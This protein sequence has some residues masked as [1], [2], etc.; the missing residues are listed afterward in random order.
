MINYLVSLLIGISFLVCQSSLN[1]RFTSLDELETKINQWHLDFG[2]NINPFPDFAPNVGIIFHHEII[3]YTGVDN[4]PIWAI[5]LSFNADIDED[6]PKILILGQCH[7]EEIYGLEMENKV[8]Q[9]L[10]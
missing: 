2:S 10:N 6:E 7:A 4:L 3:G 9:N 1:D 8:N 5:K